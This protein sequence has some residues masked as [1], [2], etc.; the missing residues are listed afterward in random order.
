MGTADFD[1][2]EWAK[3]FAL[4][5]AE[6]PQVPNDEE[7]MVTW[8]AGALM[9]G[10]DHARREY[11]TDILENELLTYTQCGTTRLQQLVDLFGEMVHDKSGDK[12]ARIH[13]IDSLADII[14]N[15]MQELQTIATPQGGAR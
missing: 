5:I 15:Q 4:T 1:A 3:E 2:R 10:H 12:E 9:A 13:R 6:Y 7:T 11:N 8:F 14:K